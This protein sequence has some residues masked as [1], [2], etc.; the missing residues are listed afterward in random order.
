MFVWVTA[1]ASPIAMVYDR[2]M[3]C[4]ARL[5]RFG[6]QRA[7][8]LA[9]AR[10]PT[11]RVLLA[12]STSACASPHF[13][14]V[15]PDANMSSPTP[16]A[17]VAGPDAAS[18]RDDAGNSAA[19]P[20]GDADAGPKVDPDAGQ[21]ASAHPPLDQEGP[22]T[23]GPPDAGESGDANVAAVDPATFPSW[24][25]PLLGDYV[26]QSYRFA[27]ER[28]GAV[29]RV[30]IFS[31]AHI[32]RNGSGAQ[33]QQQICALLEESDSDRQTVANPTGLREVRQ[34]QFM[35]GSWTTDASPVGYGYDRDVPA[36]CLGK[37]NQAIPRLPEQKW[38]SG[39]T[40]RCPSSA[41]LAPRIDDCRVRDPDGDGKPGI[42]FADISKAGQAIA[43]FHTVYVNRS[44][45]V[46][47]R[48]AADQR[49]YADLVVDDVAYQMSCEPAL[50]PQI[51]DLSRPCTSEYNGLQ[52]V[53]LPK[54]MET[55]GC[56]QLV[57]RK[58]EF[59]P[60]PPP[61][62]PANCTQQTLTDDPTRQ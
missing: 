44:H 57:P 4:A 53:P 5:S 14:A 34:L 25:Q 10:L 48:I 33:M 55:Y 51:S 19:A 13:G 2:A 46:R 26:V 24:A 31:L 60:D 58:A 36:A 16:G 30:S 17:V 22:V 18:A 43:T 41:E 1:L 29:S 62:V 3:K 20:N 12:L 9:G 35:D 40:C 38:L 21:V 47:G 39:N 28:S 37:E 6:A 23:K 8:A 32:T 50:C 11:V 42:S 7:W 54:G 15:G 45:G 56:D 27:R 61:A 49:H 52:F 59:F